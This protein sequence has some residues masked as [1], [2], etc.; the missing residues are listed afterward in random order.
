MVRHRESDGWLEVS[1]TNNCAAIIC[2]THTHKDTSLSTSAFRKI[3]S[4]ID[5]CVP[6]Y[7]TERSLRAILL[8]FV[9]EMKAYGKSGM[10]FPLIGWLLALK[11]L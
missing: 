3:A 1:L 11:V 2:Y 8:L 9:L 10:K 4:K 6:S 7:T 5:T